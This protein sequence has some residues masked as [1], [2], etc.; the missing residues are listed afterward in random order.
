M[1]TVFLALFWLSY[2]VF[3]PA[4]SPKPRQKPKILAAH[5]YIFSVN[6]LDAV[7][8]QTFPELPAGL[9][10]IRSIQNRGDHANSLCAGRQHF[11][12]VL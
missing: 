9:R 2:R 6:A 4:P 3:K 12:K 7:L 10:H 1:D 11:I 8:Q 5:R